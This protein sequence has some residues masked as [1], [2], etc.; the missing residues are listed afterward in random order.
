MMLLYKHTLRTKY[1]IVAI[2]G[3]DNSYEHLLITEIIDYRMAGIR[4][5]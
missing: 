2:S 1:F 4:I 3:S 5:S